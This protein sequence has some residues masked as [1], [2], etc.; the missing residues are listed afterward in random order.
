[1]KRKLLFHSYSYRIIELMSDECDRKSIFHESIIKNNGETYFYVLKSDYQSIKQILDV[2]LSYHNYF[3]N[4]KAQRANY[5]QEKQKF[6]RENTR[7]KKKYQ[8]KRSR[9]LFILGLVSFI[10]ILVWIMIQV[11][12][13]SF[14]KIKYR[15]FA[16]V[17]TSEYDP[18][19][20][21]YEMNDYY[22][23]G[24]L[25]LNLTEKG[26]CIITKRRERDI[27]L[28]Y[29]FSKRNSEISFRAENPLD[30]FYQ[31]TFKFNYNRL[32]GRAYMS[33]EHKNIDL[34]LYDKL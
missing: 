7:K 34:V 28:Y 29:S 14:S 11:G 33:N 23:P 21:D 17:Y 31:D 2:H 27:V 25:K 24:K 16:I 8:L 13:P 30:S 18:I 22:D 1:M 19:T 5:I 12:L 10:L 32:N 26:E 9:N 4:D 6:F 3:E 15:T 20:L